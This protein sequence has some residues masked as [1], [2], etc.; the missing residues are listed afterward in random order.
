MKCLRRAVRLQLEAEERKWV[1]AAERKA[2]RAR[3]RERKAVKALEQA[4]AEA[5]AKAG[6]GVALL[7]RNKELE[8]Q[9]IGAGGR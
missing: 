9:P 7:Q 2:E 4:R 8:T 5:R 6:D 3:V 1:T